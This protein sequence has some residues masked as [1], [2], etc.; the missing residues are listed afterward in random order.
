[1]RFPA[2]VLA[3]N[4]AILPVLSAGMHVFGVELWLN[5]RG[6][7]LGALLILVAVPGFGGLFISLA[8]SKLPATMAMGMQV[9]EAW[10]LSA[11]PAALRLNR[12]AS[13]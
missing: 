6:Q 12:S 2:L 4:L 3:T 9:I 1:M 7:N 5:E 13:S 10:Q 11:S 8:K